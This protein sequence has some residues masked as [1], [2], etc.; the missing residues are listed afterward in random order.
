MNTA[1]TFTQRVMHGDAMGALRMAGITGGLWASGIAWATAIREVARALVPTDTID[2]VMAE[3]IAA[4]LTTLLAVGFALVL[5]MPR[6]ESQ[7]QRAVVPASS[8]ATP[9][10]AR[11]RSTS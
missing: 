10:S 5:A 7:Q 1:G 4:T 11:R 2:V 3:L 6:C 9:G 8:G